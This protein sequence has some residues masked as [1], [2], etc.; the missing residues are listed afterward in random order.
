MPIWVDPHAMIEIQVLIHGHPAIS[1]RSIDPRNDTE[2]LNPAP[3][4]SSNH[5]RRAPPSPISQ[6]T[7]LR[8]PDPNDHLFPNFPGRPNSIQFPPTELSNTIYRQS[9]FIQA[10]YWTFLITDPVPTI[11]IIFPAPSIQHNF[12]IFTIKCTKT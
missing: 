12:A 2:R 6:A 3:L 5:P 9:V 11:F 10:I 7:K 4:P 1:D 8:S